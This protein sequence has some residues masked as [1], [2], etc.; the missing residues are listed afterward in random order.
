MKPLIKQYDN[1][2]KV[3]PGGVS[4]IDNGV[5]VLS[6]LLRSNHLRSCNSSVLFVH[7]TQINSD[8]TNKSFTVHSFDSRCF[9]LNTF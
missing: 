5:F 6:L 3:Q 9:S 2:H 8:A 7:H 1:L 4:T